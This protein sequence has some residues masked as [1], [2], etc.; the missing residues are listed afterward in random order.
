MDIILWIITQ[1]YFMYFL[2]QIIPV[3]NIGSSFSWLLCPFDIPLPV[4]VCVCVCAHMH[5]C[6][7]VCVLVL[8][9]FMTLQDAPGSS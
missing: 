8:P 1:Y 5:V 9:Y 7:R 3:L 2:A 4:C 6:A